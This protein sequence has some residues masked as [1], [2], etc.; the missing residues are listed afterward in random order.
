MYEDNVMNVHYVPLFPSK[1]VEE[2]V[3]EEYSNLNKDVQV[4]SSSNSSVS[5]SIIIVLRKLL[6]S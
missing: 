2:D 6:L 5:V 1:V 4:G 3:I